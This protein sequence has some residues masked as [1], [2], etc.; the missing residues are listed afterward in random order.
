M[1]MGTGNSTGCRR[2]TNKIATRPGRKTHSGSCRRPKLPRGLVERPMSG[3][4]HITLVSNV[5]PTATLLSRKPVSPASPLSRS[6]K[7]GLLVRLGICDLVDHE[8]DTALGDNVRDAVAKLDRHHSI[9]GGDA[10]HR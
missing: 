2:S 1:R 7:Q 8:A 6:R 10:E 9:G 5:I 3:K 4:P